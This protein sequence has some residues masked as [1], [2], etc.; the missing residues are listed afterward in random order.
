MGFTQ[1]FINSAFVP[2]GMALIASPIIIHLINRM[3]FRKVRFAAMEFLLK[4]DQ[5]NRR[6]LL[7][8]QLLLLLLRILIVLALLALIARLI[9]DPRLTVFG[10]EGKAH[11]LV[12]LDDSAS[13]QGGGAFEEAKKVILKLVRE[14]AKRPQTQKFSMVLLSKPNEFVYPQ[15]DVSDELAKDL[16]EKFETLKP[17]YQKGDLQTG[18]EIAGKH[19]LKE[20]ATIKY[21]H[22]FSDFREADWQGK[23]AL[24]DVINK[25]EEDEIS[26][27]LVRSIEQ[28]LPNLGITTLDGELHSVAVGVPV[29]LKIGVTNFGQEIVE[30]VGV[31]V[32]QDSDK[33]PL[34]VT[35]DKINPGEEMI[36]NKDITFST[37]GLHQVRLELGEDSLSADNARHLSIDIPKQNYVLIV[38]ADPSSIAT[39]ALKFALD[40]S[41]DTEG[42]P[43]VRTGILPTVVQY[44]LL[45]KELETGLSQFR[46]IYM[47]GVPGIPAKALPLLESYVHGGG[48]LVWFLGDNINVDSYNQLSGL[49]ANEAGELTREGEALFPVLL[50]KSPAAMTQ[51]ATV[52][53]PDLYFKTHPVF[54][55]T[56]N[57]ENK[58]VSVVRVT[59]YHPVSPD[60][61]Q[62]DLR[63]DDGVTT[64]GYTR[65]SSPVAFEHRFGQGKVMTILTSVGEPWNNLATEAGG[66]FVPVIQK[67]QQ[68]VAKPD[69]EKHTFEIGETFVRNDF[70]SLNYEQDIV[71]NHPT[72]LQQPYKMEHPLIE[73]PE[74][75]EEES[76]TNPEGEDGE[77]A[78]ADA[79]EEAQR[80]T[81][82]WETRYPYLTDP[83]IY[84]Y[85]LQPR[86]NIQDSGL[87]TNW[88]FACNL[89]PAEG[90]TAI[91][92]DETIRAHLDPESRVGIHTAANPE[93][94]A[95]GTD[96]GQE[97]RKYL[98]YLLL[99]LFVAEQAMAYRLSYHPETAEAVA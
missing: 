42:T 3:R 2:A 11:H 9:L 70:S 54:D 41:Q 16:L 95:P 53:S 5:R 74:P 78:V 31:T 7:L 65:E 37:E 77:E 26:V 52:T 27:N 24:G 96:P 1:Y 89:S 14:G 56:F 87:T 4:A 63:R 47:V 83:G 32:V 93:F 67:L 72:L 6:R 69:E 68:H 94:I 76:P 48:G 91:A 19:L 66:L 58:L 10:G 97:V 36:V 38:T 29:R 23:E 73:K 59:G 34:S 99:F 51:D 64:V 25:L 98:M 71:W 28:P 49:T 86:S 44:D 61:V 21:L 80:D 92:D 30:N 57:K 12:I 35:F 55:D 39:D 43:R 90:Q 46:A 82:R 22:V 17:T 84:R 60:W 88:E 33:L 79:A 75:S 40:P 20:E 15:V 45:D 85:T 13:M 50:A 81:S 18:L 8:E 62:D